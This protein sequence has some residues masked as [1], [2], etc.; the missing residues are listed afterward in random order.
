VDTLAQDIRYAAR[1]LIRSP[2]FTAIVIATLALATGA[3]T[4]VFSIVNGVLLKPLP[5][6]M[7]QQ[8]VAVGLTSR[9]PGDLGVISG[10]DYLDYRARNHS[11]TDIAAFYTGNVNLIVRGSAPV[12]LTSNNVRGSFFDVLGAPMER[13]RPLQPGDDARGADRV[14]VISDH[15]WRSIFNADPSIVGKTITVDGKT[16]TVVGVASPR[17]VFPEGVDV[18]QPLVFENWMIEPGNRGAH[19]LAAV[20]RLRPG[21]TLDAAKRDMASLGEA[22]RAQYPES[23]ANARVAVMSLDDLVVG[24]VRRAL[25]T[26]FGAVAFVLLIA[27]ANIANLLLIRASARETEMALRTALGAGRWRIMRQLITESVLLSIVGAVLGC[28]LASW[29]VSDRK[30]SRA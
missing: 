18:W 30:V 15:V 23:N 11:F 26:M 21:V 14:V 12:R 3:T 28:L 6:R 19:W 8:L 2:G 20:A 27:C 4:A 5:L 1:K 17:L 24:N 16:A 13:G 10:P 7:P 22:L 29:P 25:W 9:N